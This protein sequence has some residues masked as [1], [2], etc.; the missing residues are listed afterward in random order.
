[1]LIQIR[2]LLSM[3]MEVRVL[4]NSLNGPPVNRASPH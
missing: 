1:M 2:I 4:L 3:I